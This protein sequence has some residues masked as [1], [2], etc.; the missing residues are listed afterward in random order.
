ME[1]ADIKRLKELEDEN[2]RLKLMVADLTLEN[3]AIKEVLEVK[4]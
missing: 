4:R 3:R 1:A 2:R